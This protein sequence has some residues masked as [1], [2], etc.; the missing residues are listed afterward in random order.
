MSKFK[1]FT[2]GILLIAMVF[3][4]TS[5]VTYAGSSGVSYSFSIEDGCMVTS[6]INGSA[7]KAKVIC[8]SSSTKSVRYHL[9]RSYGS[10]WTCVYSGSV[11][12]GETVQ[13]NYHSAVTS[14]ALWRTYV[15]PKSTILPKHA[16]GSAYCYT[17]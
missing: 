2:K 13:T 4:M 16:S 8:K 11:S 15:Y 6:T 7:G 10:G 9:Q 1:T 12:P 3:V 14:K 5:V 17:K